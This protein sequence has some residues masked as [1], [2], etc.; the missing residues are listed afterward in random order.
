MRPGG[1]AGGA[2]LAG[3]ALFAL[4]WVGGARGQQILQYGFEGREPV[5]VAGAADAPY[6]VLAHRLAEQAKGEP[7]HSGQ[8]CEHLQVQAEKGNYIH[9]TFDV[10]RAPIN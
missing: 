10:G 2:L 3:A 6:K 5:W 8:R 9:Y 1:W 4:G 7:C